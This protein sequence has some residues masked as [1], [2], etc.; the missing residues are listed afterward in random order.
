MASKHYVI[1]C[2]FCFL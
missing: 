1:F 2:V